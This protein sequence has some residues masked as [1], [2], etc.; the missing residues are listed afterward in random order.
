MCLGR[1]RKS[2][3]VLGSLSPTW[4]IRMDQLAKLVEP[5][6]CLTK[7][8]FEQFP[9]CLFLRIV[10]LMNKNYRGPASRLPGRTRA[11]WLL[12]HGRSDR[13]PAGTTGIWTSGLLSSVLAKCERGVCGS[14][15][16]TGRERVWRGGKLGHILAPQSPWLL[17]NW[18]QGPCG[19]ATLL[20]QWKL[21]EMP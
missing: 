3:L 13:S 21:K 1:Q 18:A 8:G 17:H 19:W 7:T 15:P 2:A 11:C 20:K 14:S 5:F 12:S 16:G 10:G 6:L 9:F 4:A